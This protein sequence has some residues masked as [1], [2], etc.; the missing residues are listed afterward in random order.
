M[1]KIFNML[2][3]NIKLNN[4]NLLRICF[5]LLLFLTILIYNLYIRVISGSAVGGDDFYKNLRITNS[6]RE[7]PL[8]LVCHFAIDEKSEY[9]YPGY[10]F[11][12]M[13]IDNFNKYFGKSLNVQ[14]NMVLISHG[15]KIAQIIYDVNW[16][17]TNYKYEEFWGSI[18]VPKFERSFDPNLIYVYVTG[19]SANLYAGRMHLLEDDKNI[20]YIDDEPK[21][22]VELW[23][24]ENPSFE[25]IWWLDFVKIGRKISRL[26]Y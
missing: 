16:D 8:E 14:N 5:L 4:F 11:D 25:R 7:I 6:T 20:R 21:W 2:N 18:A 15:R 23:T 1:K 3:K 13:D 17:L 12:I 10:Y 19:F 9:S 24:K 22:E 26:P